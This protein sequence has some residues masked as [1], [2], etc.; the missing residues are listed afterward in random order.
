MALQDGGRELLIPALEVKPSS[1]DLRKLVNRTVNC[2]AGGYIQGLQ[3]EMTEGVRSYSFICAVNDQSKYLESSCYDWLANDVGGDFDLNLQTGEAIRSVTMNYDAKTRDHIFVFQICSFAN[4]H[5]L[6][7]KMY[8]KYSL[9]QRNKF[10]DEEESFRYQSACNIQQADYYIPITR[11]DSMWSDQNTDRVFQTECD[12]T[13]HMPCLSIR[14]VS[15][16]GVQPTNGDRW[17]PQDWPSSGC[18]NQEILIRWSSDIQDGARR[19]YF[20]CCVLATP[21]IDL[22]TCQW[23]NAPSDKSYSLQNK[24]GWIIRGIAAAFDT[25]YRDRLM[26]FETCQLRES[27]QTSKCGFAYHSFDSK[28][29]E[30]VPYTFRIEQVKNA[31]EC[32]LACNKHPFCMSAGYEPLSTS[33]EAS[34]MCFLSYRRSTLTCPDTLVDTVTVPHPVW[35]YCL[36]CNNA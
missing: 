29:S 27:S 22:T 18:E 10:G 7:E 20:G 9:Q 12:D 21:I 23:E 31:Q 24:K 33:N 3:G 34:A 26:R 25:K 2:T 35:I 5:A 32:A 36:D 4:R 1:D 30:M 8:Q 13:L 28:A 6:S 11:L 15:P 16:D 14:E 17:S 19:Y